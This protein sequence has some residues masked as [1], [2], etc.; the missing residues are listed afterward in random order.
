MNIREQHI[1]DIVAKDGTTK[2]Y[3]VTKLPATKGNKVFKKISSQGL[4]SLDEDE[5]KQLIVD[6][7]SMKPETFEIE[8]SGRMKALYTLVGEILQ[9]NFEDVFQ[10]LDSEES[11]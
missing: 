6:S 7:C 9:Y 4:D 3:T 2:S 11:A 5:I 10:E 8:F 1:F